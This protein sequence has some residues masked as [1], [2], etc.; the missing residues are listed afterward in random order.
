MKIAFEKISPTPK[1]VRGE[2]NGVTL[3]GTLYKKARH[4]A[5]VDGEINGVLSLVCDRCGK[6]FEHEVDTRIKLTLYDIVSKDK[7]DLDIIEFLDG[8]VDTDY[9]VE[10]ECNAIEGSYH[11][12][13]ACEA[14]EEALEMEF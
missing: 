4:Q 9:I 10:S 13:D 8:V 7:E 14:S 6:D 2:C 11:Y 5:I 1:A 3:S 12:C